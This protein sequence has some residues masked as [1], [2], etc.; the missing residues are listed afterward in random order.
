MKPGSAGKDKLDSRWE[1]GIFLGVREASGEWYIGTPS[2][3]L[4]VHTTKELSHETESWNAEALDQMKGT[5][6]GANTR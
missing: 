6:M 5:P 4:T 1:K 2:G 3:V